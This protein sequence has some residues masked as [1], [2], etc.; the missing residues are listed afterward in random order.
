MSPSNL[1]VEII[2]RLTRVESK[3]DTLVDIPARIQDLESEAKTR[4]G[5]FKWGFIT[6]GGTLSIVIADLLA[7]LLHLGG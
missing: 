1:D 7:H 5:F 2:E 6:L 4:R 3:I